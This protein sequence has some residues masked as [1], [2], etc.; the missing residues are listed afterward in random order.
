MSTKLTPDDAQSIISRSSN[1]YKLNTTLKPVDLAALKEK[2]DP[3]GRKVKA[4][5][6]ID[7]TFTIVE[8]RPV[9]STLN[10]EQDH[11][12][13]VKAVDG[14]GELMN[15]S[16]SSQRL[17]EALDDIAALNAE[18]ASARE[19]GDDERVKELEEVGAGRPMT[20]TLREVKGG[21]YGRYYTFE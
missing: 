10:P 16:L 13:W 19:M 4:R 2:I 18:L 6:L 7:T 9:E 15:F 8:M 1:P 12:Y 17:V 20:L 11:Y 14:A 3:Q 5:D 21:K